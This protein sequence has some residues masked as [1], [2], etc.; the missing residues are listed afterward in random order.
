[1]NVPRRRLLALA[2]GA[3]LAR[4]ALAPTPASASTDPIDHAIRAMLEADDPARIAALAAPLTGLGERGAVAPLIHLLYWLDPPLH[5]PIAEALTALTGADHA[6]DWTAWMVWQQQRT[7]F[8]PWPGFPR[9]QADLL[10]AIDP[11]YA[12]LLAPDAP[13]TIRREEIVWGSL[14]L[15]GAPPLD[16]PALEPA[17]AADW[18]ADTDTVFATRIAGLPRAWPLRILAWHEVVNDTIGR[19]PVTLAFCPLAGSAT[20]H[21]TARRG[22]PPLT[23]GTTGLVHR[24]AKLIHDRETGALWNPLSG[25]PVLGDLATTETR[26][27]LL[28]LVATTWGAWRQAHPDTMVLSRDTGHRRDYAAPAPLAGYATTESLYFPAALSDEHRPAKSRLFAVRQGEAARAWPLSRFAGGAVLRDRLADTDL[29]LLGN[30]ATEDIRAYRGAAPTLRRAPDGTLAD[31]AGPWTL[32][33]EALTGP[34]GQTL[35]R[36][37]GLTTYRFA[38]A[39]AFPGTIST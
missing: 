5:P 36:L 6:T 39:N 18:L 8:P 23:F 19:L 13:A 37:P 16:H 29:L 30:G 28:P 27:D 25:R 35:P 32:T 14:T 4:P 21:A 34:T 12:R 33:E 3:I 17:F 38:W 24:A 2:P 1:M 7:D 26:L 9:L 11:R 22:A 15:D 10:A 20:L 31:D